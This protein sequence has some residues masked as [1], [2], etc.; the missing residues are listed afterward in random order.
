MNIMCH[1]QLC[2][3]LIQMNIMQGEHWIKWARQL[4]SNSS[5]SFVDIAYQ[6]GENV[7]KISL[8][9]CFSE[10]LWCNRSARMRHG[11]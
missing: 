11:F 2:L 1:E 5:F 10:V 7:P 9:I 8:C 6:E 3:T 4:S